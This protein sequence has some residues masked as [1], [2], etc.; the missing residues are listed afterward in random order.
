MALI[1]ISGRND[2]WWL[3]ILVVRAPFSLYGGWVT[4]ATIL[5]TVYMLKS[6]GMADQPTLAK[7]LNPK[8]WKWA[9]FMMFMSEETWT[10]LTV[11]GAEIFYEIFSYEERNPFYGSVFIW[12]L[13]ALLENNVTN[14]PY[15]TNLIICVSVILGIH[16]ISMAGLWSYLIFE[17]LQ[18]FYEP[19][20]FWNHGFLG[21]A[22]YWA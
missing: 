18:P 2:V 13:S 15:N 5:N 21:K 12:V 4:A 16:I 20:S 3:E 10:C 19:I 22:D 8:A 7:P 9:D 17:E 1:V 14:K 11:W 6:W